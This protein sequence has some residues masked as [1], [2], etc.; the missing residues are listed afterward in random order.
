MRSGSPTSSSGSRSSIRLSR[1]SPF[2]AA[3]WPITDS[4]RATVFCRLNGVHSRLISPAAILVRSSRSLMIA[5]SV[6]PASLTFSRY[7]RW[8]GS[9]L[10]VQR[11]R[12]EPD[13]GVE[14]RPQFVADVGQEGILDPVGD[15][16][17]FQ[18]RLQGAVLLVEAEEHPRLGAQQLVVDRLCQ[19]IGGARPVAMDAILGA[20]VG[21]GDEDH[22][23]VGGLRIGRQAFADLEAVHLGH[24]D[25]EEDQRE[26]LFEGDRQRVETVAGLDDRRLDAPEG[27]PD[28]QAVGGQVIDDEDLRNAASFRAGHGF[29]E[30]PQLGLHGAQVASRSRI[31]SAL[32]RTRKPPRCR[33][34][35]KRSRA[36]ACSASPK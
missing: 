23:R 35:S 6:W 26:F 28:R 18:R 1:R 17:R 3:W 16:R 32:P 15:F 5:S 12:R 7:S 30:N 19:I 8:R 24:L 25:V 29:S 14:R 11:Q 22:R 2:R 9:L 20:V 36:R 21:G 31:D 27:G 4:A 13:D 33:L 34:R 10:L